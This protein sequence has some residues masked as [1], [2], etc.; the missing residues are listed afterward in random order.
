[1]ECPKCNTKIQFDGSHCSF[2]G[3]IPTR[4]PNEKEI[5]ET[6]FNRRNRFTH[7]RGQPNFNRYLN[8]TNESIYSIDDYGIGKIYQ[9]MAILETL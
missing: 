8:D 6:T 2:C 5:A 3:F 7:R 1:M 9:E 4:H